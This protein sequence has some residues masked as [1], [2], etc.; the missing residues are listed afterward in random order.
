MPTRKLLLA[1]DSVTIQ[2][3]VNLTFAD[4]GIEVITV[5][6]GDAAM[7]KFNESMPDL[8]MVDVNMPGLDGY[9]ICEIIKNDDET[10]HIPVILLVGSFEPFDE[11]E[12]RR[13][14]ADDFLTKPFQSIRQLVNKVSDLLVD[15]KTGNADNEAAAANSFDDTLES[16]KPLEEETAATDNFGDAGMDDEMI[17][18]SQI[19]TFPVNPPVEFMSEPL[20]EASADKDSVAEDEDFAALEEPYAF[21]NK[22]EYSSDDDWA[23][24][25]P[26]L[27]EDSDEEGENSRKTAS[28]E[29][30]IYEFADE[31]DSAQ[32]DFNKR[33]EQILASNQN[34]DSAQEDP[35]VFALD[36]LNLLEVPNSKK[37]S[38]SKSQSPEEPEIL[39]DPTNENHGEEHAEI[40]DTSAFINSFSPEMIDALADKIV[41]KIS[42]RVIKKI[43]R[44]TVSQMSKRK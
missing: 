20:Y 12:A 34:L 5:G 1:D 32:E 4:E 25:Q 43:V 7:E 14:G 3:V 29:R 27:K 22:A 31:E 44:E 42:D 11:E 37:G 9:R 28:S 13:I 2:K 19:S 30:E 39:D 40:E 36:D 17:Q 15:E 23:E 10:K 16:V 38:S 8:V 6:D 24:T 41:E 26:L 18:T 35:T 21:E 33:F